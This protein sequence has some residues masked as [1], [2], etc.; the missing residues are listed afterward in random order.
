ME[1]LGGL[2]DDLHYKLVELRDAID[3]TWSLDAW[4]VSSGLTHQAER[5]VVLVSQADLVRNLSAIRKLLE[6]AAKI[7]DEPL[8]H[9]VSP[10]D[11]P[12]DD[13]YFV[14][15]RLMRARYALDTVEG[16]MRLQV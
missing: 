3:P 14:L 6:R 9:P 5:L 12:Y 11:S 7:V 16:A 13:R 2:T 8:I 1:I 4:E 10:H 15:S